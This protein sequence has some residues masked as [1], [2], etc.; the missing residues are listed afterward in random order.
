[1]SVTYDERLWIPSAGIN[2][3][4][5]PVPAAPPQPH[6]QRS[7]PLAFASF[8]A[9]NA[10]LLIRPGEILAP[11]RG[12]PIYEVVIV[13]CTVLS[14]PA[15]L[16]QFSKP[17]L[18]RRPLT[19]FVL[20]MLAA[21]ILSHLAHMRPYV[22]GAFWSALE[23]SK[24]V[25]YYLLLVANLTTLAR[26]RQFLLWLL[27]FIVVLAAVA[28]LQY[29]DLIHIEGVQTL[30]E[31]DVDDDTGE[32]TSI[33]RLQ[34]TG[35][36]NDPNDLCLILLSGMAITAYALGNWVVLAP[37]W[38]GLLGLFGYALTL[39]Q[40]R[41]GFIALVGGVVVFSFARFGKWK[42]LALAAV[43][44]PAVL[45]L[46]SGRQTNIDLGN[47]NDTAQARVQLWSEGLES[48]KQAPLFG[49]GYG[50]Y[51]DEA[52]QVAHNSF[53]HSFTELG[54]FGGTMFV[55]AFGC[56]VIGVRRCRAAVDPQARQM[57]PYLLI[58]VAM[59]IFGILSLSRQYIA[60][61]YMVLGLAAAFTEVAAPEP[62]LLTKRLVLRL[63]GLSVLVLAVIY[64]F[65]KVMLHLGG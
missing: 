48:F 10:V 17:A 29:H 64:V 47:R 19:L 16:A 55:G 21:V 4:G 36:Y 9:V 18:T 62:L 26:L 14:F 20:G 6:A 8:I 13:L 63:V 53:V 31:N 59:Y 39:T 34:S 40:S 23:F 65:V 33:L 15:L 60:P 24:S 37:I 52:T 2:A 11:V 42:A 1:M 43:A 61:T 12:L 54:F 30:E 38:L 41:G 50:G 44:L 57:Y 35:I 27:A 3:E 22:G 51:A 46:F 5:T 58:V 32:V 7:N 28:L 25:L 45:L 56:A 49:I